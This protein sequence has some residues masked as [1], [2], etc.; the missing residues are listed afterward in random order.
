M[1]RWNVPKWREE[2]KELFAP[3]VC[4]KLMHKDQLTVMFVG[5]P[6]TREDFHIEHGSEF[7]FQMQGNI[8]LP[9]IQRG[10]RKIV[11]INEGEVFLLPSRIPH[12]PQ[13]PERGSFGLVV[14]RRREKHELDGLRYYR[15]FN[16]CDEILWEKYFHCWDLGRDLVPVIQEYKSST[17]FETKKPTGKYV[18]RNPPTIVDSYTE[19]PDPFSFSKWVR[20]NREALD[21]GKVLNLFEGHPDREFSVLVAGENRR[22]PIRQWRHETWLYQVEG[23]ATLSILPK[24]G[25]EDGRSVGEKTQM[26]KGDCCIVPAGCR[27]SIDRGPGSI[28]I[29]LFNDPLGNKRHGLRSKI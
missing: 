18:E 4:N 13:R 1:Q 3:P 10:K 28:G 26:E 17:E 22:P 11:K 12:S 2:N 15:N 14:E 25:H 5:G 9:T 24:D 16:N 27:F 8:E 21:S 19:V 7:F 29:V 6:N 20:N 23:T